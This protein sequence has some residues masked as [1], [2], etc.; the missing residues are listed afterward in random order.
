MNE[1]Y[2]AL[3]SAGVAIVGAVAAY[4]VSYFKSKQ[5][6]NE[7]DGIKEQLNDSN[8]LYYITCPNC[9][10]KIYLNSVQI[11]AEIKKE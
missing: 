4:F 1:L 8:Q 9:G 3:I 5:L 2:A 6:K 10:T 7:L 11:N